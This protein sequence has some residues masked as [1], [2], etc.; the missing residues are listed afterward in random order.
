MLG[1]RTL[2]VA[3]KHAV[4]PARISQLRREFYRDWMRFGNDTDV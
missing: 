3:R 1:D 2:E 4:S